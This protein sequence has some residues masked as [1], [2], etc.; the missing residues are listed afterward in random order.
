MALP[1]N[2][3]NRG[4]M[5]RH[6]LVRSQSKRACGKQEASGVTGKRCVLISVAATL[7]LLY[8]Q[9]CAAAESALERALKLTW[10]GLEAELSWEPSAEQHL[11]L[12]TGATALNPPLALWSCNNICWNNFTGVQVYFQILPGNKNSTKFFKSFAERP[13]VRSKLRICNINIVV[14]LFHMA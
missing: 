3:G 4:K 7:H 5:V 8:G 9:C 1:G 11:S 12:L 2:Q 13:N 14:K 6:K 10:E